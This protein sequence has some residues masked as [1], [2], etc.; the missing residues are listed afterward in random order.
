MVALKMNVNPQNIVRWLQE[1]YDDLDNVGPIVQQL[2][3]KPTRQLPPTPPSTPPSSAQVG[4]AH[5]LF[6]PRFCLFVL[7]FMLCILHCSSWNLFM[8]EIRVVFPRG[9][10]GAAESGYQALLYVRIVE[11]FAVFVPYC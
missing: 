3:K 8:L 10:A 4:L 5:I 6:F 7:R 2:P 9:K 1:T 11:I